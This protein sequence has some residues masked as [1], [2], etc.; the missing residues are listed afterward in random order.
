MPGCRM[1]SRVPP[2]LA[3]SDIR[4]AETCS[5][6]NPKADQS[7]PQAAQVLLVLERWAIVQTHVQAFSPVQSR[8]IPVGKSP[9]SMHK[10]QRRWELLRRFLFLPSCFF[11]PERIE[12]RI[13]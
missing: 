13:S 5:R 8:E 6:L 2:Q 3:K 9:A 7:L 10:T 4:S 11:L 1:V 12:F